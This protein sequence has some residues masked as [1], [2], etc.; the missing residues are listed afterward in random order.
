MNLV[1]A[2]RGRIDAFWLL[3]YGTEADVGAYNACM[4]YA[5]SLFQIRGAFYPVIAARLPALLDAGDRVAL[6][7]F[8]SRQVRWVALL[9]TPLFVLFA[10]L[11]DGLLAVFGKGFTH[12]SHGARAA[13]RGAVRERALA[14]GV[15]AAARRQRALQ[16][17]RGLRGGEPPAR[18][19]ARAHPTLRPRRGRPSRSCSRS[20]WPRSSRSCSRGERRAPTAS[21]AASRSRSLA[22]VAAWIAARAAQS[23][24]PDDVAMRF[25]GGAAAGAVTYLVAVFATGLEPAERAIVDD[26]LVKLRRLARR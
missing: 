20:S 17:P 7:E 13:R 10:G 11:G 3:R 16:H 18:G 19:A 23:A 25:F 22:G 6:N 15:H 4:L 8:L 12:A 5:V 2:L 21:R 9:A 24:L 26:G 1:A 14:A